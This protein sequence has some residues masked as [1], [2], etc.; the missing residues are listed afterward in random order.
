MSLCVQSHC[1]YKSHVELFS[2][3]TEFEIWAGFGPGGNPKK[4]C[5]FALRVFF[6]AFFSDTKIQNYIFSTFIDIIVRKL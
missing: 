1:I 4:F 2:Y 6:H 3:V 5:N